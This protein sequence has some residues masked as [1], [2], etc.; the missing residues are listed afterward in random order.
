MIR[1]PAVAGR[2]YP[3]SKPDL[4]R[5]LER[6][7]SRSAFPKEVIGLIAPHAG[8]LFS[9][10][11]AGKAFGMVAI[12]ESVII[13]G[14]DHRGCG[15]PLVVDGNDYWRTPLGDVEVDDRLR[16][17]LLARSKVFRSETDAGRKEHS[18]EVQVPFIQFL[19]PQAKILP[20]IVSSSSV[21]DLLEAGREIASAIRDDSRTLLLASTDM[22]HFIDAVQARKKDYMA[23]REIERLDP[24]S[25]FETVRANGISMCGAAPT[26]MMLEASKRLG[27][28]QVKEVEY[29]NSGLVT[30][31]MKEVVAYLSMLVY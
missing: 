20:I 16:R 9:G 23:V 10:S 14:V 24:A 30:G 26:T 19:N 27:A 2:F 12:P 28:T 11:C 25:L 3:Y 7:V 1:Q 18:L 29:T 13:M 17:R 21:Q 8:Y 31:N 4:E 15:S 22:S 5:E 6:C